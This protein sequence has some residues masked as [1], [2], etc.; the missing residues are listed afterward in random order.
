MMHTF[1]PGAFL[2]N[3]LYPNCCDCC[4]R[5]I[6][7]DALICT[8]C[9]NELNQLRVRNDDWQKQ[10]PTLTVPWDGAAAVCKYA[11]AAKAGILA[12]KDGKTN[13]VR[14]IGTEL[15]ASV[16]TLLPDTLPDIVTWVPVTKRRRR[17]QGYAHSERLAK[18]CAAAL[19][20][21]TSGKL[22]EEHAGTLRQHELPKELRAVYAE[23]FTHT[24]VRLDG[25][26]VLLCDDL[27]TTGSTL[28][29]CTNQLREAGAEKVY[30]AVMAYRI[31]E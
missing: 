6:P 27:L 30:I 24:N 21:P 8:D 10:N 1:R 4:Q 5:R 23:R 9:A 28:M 3:L 12:A 26:T 7:Y 25:K 16:R 31:K 22:L 29:R 17:Q 18:T 15:A 13:F 19:G 11:G 2:L 14:L 20:I